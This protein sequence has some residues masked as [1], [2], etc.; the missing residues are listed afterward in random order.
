MTVHTSIALVFHSCPRFPSPHLIAPAPKKCFTHPQTMARKLFYYLSLADVHFPQARTTVCKLFSLFL[1]VFPLPLTRFLVPL[2]QPFREMW[3]IIQTPYFLL[4]LRLFLIYPFF[5]CCFQP[6][7]PSLILLPSVPT[8][9]QRYR[10]FIF[11]RL[12]FISS[13]PRRRI[14]FVICHL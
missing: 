6:C 11:S 8:R 5:F 12:L 1:F 14:I 9:C 10:S 3:F 13:N 4:L 2:R 7:L